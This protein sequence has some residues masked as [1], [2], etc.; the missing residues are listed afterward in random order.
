MGRDRGPA[1]SYNGAMTTNVLSVPEI[2]CNHCKAA[3]ESAVGVVPGVARV[4]VD[5]DAKTVTVE[6]DAAAD[7]VTAAIADAGYDV[8]GPA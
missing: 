3:I 1:R 6:G 5:V 8:A 2:S 7:A 4:A